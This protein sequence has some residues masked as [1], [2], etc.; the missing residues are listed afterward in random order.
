MVDKYLNIS[1]GTVVKN[2]EILKFV[3]GYLKTKTYLSMQLK[4]CPIYYDMFQ[5]NIGLNKCVIMLL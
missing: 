5:I 2:P 3:P 1:I 4:N